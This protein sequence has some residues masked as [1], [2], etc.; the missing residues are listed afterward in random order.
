MDLWRQGVASEVGLCLLPMV[1][2]TSES[3]YEDAD[4]MPI[5]Y[6]GTRLTDRQLQLLSRD[7]QKRFT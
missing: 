1:R 6:G 5:P 7:Y 4:W 2:L 3:K